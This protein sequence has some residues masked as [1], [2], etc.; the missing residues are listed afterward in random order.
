M[1]CVLLLG[2]KIGKWKEKEASSSEDF[3][4]P[5]SQARRLKLLFLTN[6]PVPIQQSVQ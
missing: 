3:R 6:I 5:I 2:K 4:Q 1:S